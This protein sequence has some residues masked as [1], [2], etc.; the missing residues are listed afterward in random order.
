MKKIPRPNIEDA[1]R[2]TPMEMNNLHFKL[3]TTHTPVK[4]SVKENK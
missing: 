4:S 1:V 3:P 2:L